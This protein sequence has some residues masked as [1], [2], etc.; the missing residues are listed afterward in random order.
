MK[1]SKV[2]EKVES[3]DVDALKTLIEE[4]STSDYVLIDVR[5]PAEYSRAHIPGALSMPM[6]D[7]VNGDV[8]LP[9][10]KPLIIYSRRGDR[11]KAAVQWF[12]SQDFE[13]V[14]EL[15]GGFQSW[16]GIM[17]HGQIDLNLGIVRQ[18]IEFSDALSMAYAMEE[19]L[20]QFYLQI[21]RG[22]TDEFYQ[23]LYRKLASFEVEHKQ[24]LA[25]TYAISEGKELISK[26]K[27]S[28]QAQIMEG[29]G[30]IDETLIKT[31]AN[32]SSVYDVF[33]LA[34]AFETQ[35]FDFYVRLAQHA[36]D[37]KA[38]QFFKEMADAEKQHLA[39]V[40]QE[41]NNYLDYIKQ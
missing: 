20:R 2:I 26:E 14:K 16:Q 10:R 18:D 25:E 7:L 6:N 22:T 13:D 9:D 17:A 28:Q 1:W 4:K 35:A 27:E 39:F 33:S 31:L 37:P 5:Q 41:M 24:Q 21:A 40:T 15:A 19:G 8:V 29:G 36:I 32:T 23:K 3:I 38:K 30:H 11:S 12:I 34:I